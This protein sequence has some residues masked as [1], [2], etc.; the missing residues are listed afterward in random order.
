MPLSSVILSVILP[1]LLIGKRIIFHPSFC[2]SASA[3]PRDP[4]DLRTL[5]CALSPRHVGRSYV[6][7]P[8]NTTHCQLIKATRPVPG[9]AQVAMATLRWMRSPA[10]HSYLHC[11]AERVG[12]AVQRVTGI[13]QIPCNW[14]RICLHLLT[15]FRERARRLCV[16]RRLDLKSEPRY[17]LGDY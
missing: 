2:R 11:Q 4:C 14:Q 7:L 10:F 17:V 8:L 13:M 12:A 16:F 6:G 3:P 9:Y 5:G 15:S 1:G